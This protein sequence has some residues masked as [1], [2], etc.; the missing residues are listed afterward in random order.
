MSSVDVP[1][2]IFDE[3]R[4]FRD[5][6]ASGTVTPAIAGDDVVMKIEIASVN[7]T[8]LDDH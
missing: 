8:T 4:L 5:F 1:E 2:V 7:E 6:V 3:V